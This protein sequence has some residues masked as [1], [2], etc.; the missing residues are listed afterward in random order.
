M[1]RRRQRNALP[2][3]PITADI[4]GLNHQ[5]RGITKIAGKTMFVSGA[6]PGESAR[7]KY[8]AVFS[9][10]DDGEALEIIDHPNPH[11][12]S[13]KCAHFA[14]CGGCALQHMTLE[15]QR[16]HKEN[17]LFELIQRETQTTPK[18]KL[19]PLTGEAF[20]YRRK[21]RL[22]VRHIP[23]K[24][25]VL[26]GFRERFSNF[27]AV[28]HACEV[29][30]PNVGQRIGQLREMLSAFTHKNDIPQLEIAIGDRKNVIIV[31]H[32]RPL[33]VNEKNLLIEFA[34]QNQFQILSQ[35]KGVNTIYSL[36]PENESLLLSY[37]LKDFDLT[38]SFYPWQFTQINAEINQ[39][40]IKQAIDLLDL[41]ANDTVLDLFCGIGN[42]SLPMAKSVK[43]VVGIEGEQQAIEMAQ[44]NAKHNGI[45]N[46]EFFGF[47]LQN[48]PSHESWA[49]QRFD[50]VLLDPARSGAKEIIPWLKTWQPRKIIYV[51]CNPS[52]LARDCQLIMQQGYELAAAGTMDMFPQTEH[53]E[54]MVLFEKSQT[55]Q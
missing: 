51:S 33:L 48:D 25:P 54:A 40:M 18:T 7:I 39:K 38:M 32:M 37:D 50:K 1:S 29:L 9:Q 19:A 34:K 11:R 2:Q 23:S 16:L 3:E 30:H 27:V 52:T 4:I 24:G 6:L 47:D 8:R 22:S 26:V 15:Q 10:Y 36:Y 43:K 44:R 45:D 20:G 55:E 31:R 17:T 5:G 14:V 42:F 28:M 41:Q 49:Q 13:P 53:T 21:A 46:A 12:I 35:S